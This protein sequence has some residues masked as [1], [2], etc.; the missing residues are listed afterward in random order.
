LDVLGLMNDHGAN[1]VAG[2]FKSPPHPD[3]FPRWGRGR[4]LRTATDAISNHDSC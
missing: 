1:P 4:S 2:N 3:P